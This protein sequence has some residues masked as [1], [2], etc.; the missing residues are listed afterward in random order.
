M[1]VAS[2]LW[3]RLDTPGH[4][5]CRLE[6]GATGW[7]LDGAAVFSEDGSPAQLAYR[8]ACDLAWRTQHGEVRGWLGGRAVEFS[9]SRT[10]EGL[11][12]L[13]GVLVPRLEGCVDL[14]LGFTPATNL[15]QIRRSALAVGQA[16]HVPVA[17][18][19]PSAGTLEVLPQRYERRDETTYWYE[20]PRFDYAALLEV[21]P[22]GFIQRYP[23]LW[24]AEG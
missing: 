22:S 21:G 18:L 12:T 3:R 17:W 10:S 2:A 16:A 15:T 5:A 20:A 7:A 4:D 8:I 1:I 23:G 6:Q 13:N 24:E 14:D 19:D 9:V 11:W